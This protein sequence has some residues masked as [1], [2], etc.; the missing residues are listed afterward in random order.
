M[1]TLL[2][3]VLPDA[4]NNEYTVGSGAS[5]AVLVD[6]YCCCMQKETPLLTLSPLHAHLFPRKSVYLVIIKQWQF[7]SVAML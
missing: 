7:S 4:C 3:A 2:E 1:D 6:V 5:C